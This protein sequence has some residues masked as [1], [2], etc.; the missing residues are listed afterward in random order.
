MKMRLFLAI[1][2]VL[3]LALVPFVF[4]QTVG[5]EGA[6]GGVTLAGY[7]LPVI[8]T[9]ILGFVYKMFPNIPN[10]FKA[11]IA[12]GIGIVIGIVAMVY[13]GNALTFKVVVDGILS[14]IMTGSAAVGLYEVTRVVKKEGI[15]R[16]LPPSGSGSEGGV[17]NGG[18]K[19]P[20]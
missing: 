3:T 17:V 6:A 11:A 5:T 4:A 7:S 13:Q 9:V 15:V 20:E 8:L 1:F 10:R 14:G 19:S 2:I 12:I 16:K 18:A